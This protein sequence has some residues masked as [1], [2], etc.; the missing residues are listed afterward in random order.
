VNPRYLISHPVI[1]KESYLNTDKIR[2]A[3]IS[4]GDEISILNDD[5]DSI[6][7]FC[8][9]STESLYSI[10]LNPYAHFVLSLFQTTTEKNIN[11]TAT[12]LYRIHTSQYNRVLYG[13]VLLF[14][15]VDPLDLYSS[16]QYHS[17]P[18]E[19]LE[20]LFLLTKNR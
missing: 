15:S 5:P 7:D 11:A 12:H 4:C 1:N 9:S 17:L 13:D 3:F 2:A 19:I 14:G 6:I 10:S 8:F 18:Y 16:E 20:Q